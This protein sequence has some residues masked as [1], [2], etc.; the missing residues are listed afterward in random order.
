MDTLN[1]ISSNPT[2]IQ[3]YIVIHQHF[4]SGVS[5]LVDG[6]LCFFKIHHMFAYFSLYYYVVD[7]LG[8][9]ANLTTKLFPSLGQYRY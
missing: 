9:L 2:T 1:T 4:F 5:I 3:Y 7:A 6:L 8:P